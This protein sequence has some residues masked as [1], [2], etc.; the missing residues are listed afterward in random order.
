[1]LNEHFFFML[2]LLV[3]ILQARSLASSAE[4]FAERF[5]STEGR[6]STAVMEMV[7][8]IC[9][10]QGL[11]AQSLILRETIYWRYF[12]LHWLELPIPDFDSAWDYYEDQDNPDRDNPQLL[13]LPPVTSDSSARWVP[14][15]V[16]IFLFLF[17]VIFRTD[18]F[19]GIRGRALRRRVLRRRP[20]RHRSPRSRSRFSSSR[21]HRRRLHRF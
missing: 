16:F 12:Y 10:I 5:E 1:M 17:L 9:M 14:A 6:S 2:R 21:I 15:S 19:S 8:R 11:S 7:L 18:F 13:L 20:F 3:V 4:S